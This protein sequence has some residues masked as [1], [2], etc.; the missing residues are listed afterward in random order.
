MEV[1]NQVISQEPLYQGSPFS[2]HKMPYFLG[3][4]T[5]QCV[6]ISEERNYLRR[7]G[8]SYTGDLLGDNLP[9][10]GSF[11]GGGGG[12]FQLAIIPRENIQGSIF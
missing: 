6:F 10:R 1:L 12:I 8:M 5:S 4:F 3:N 11:L 7:S 2:N 9:D